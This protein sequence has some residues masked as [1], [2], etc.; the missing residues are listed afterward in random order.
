MTN[1]A[2]IRILTSLSPIFTLLLIQV[3][4]PGSKDAGTPHPPPRPPCSF[5]L[6]HHK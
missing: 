2:G 6:P 3:W 4:T 1:G 5:L